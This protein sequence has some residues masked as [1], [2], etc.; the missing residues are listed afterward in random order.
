MEILRLLLEESGASRTKLLFF[1][2]L[3]G[4]SGVLLLAILNSGAAVAARGGVRLPL[5]VYFV[6]TLTL[7][8]LSQKFVWRTTTKTAE[9][10]VHAIRTR[11]MRKIAGCGLE[12]LDSIGRAELYAAINQHAYSISISIPPMIISLQSVVLVAFTVAYL[13]YLSLLAFLL[14][15]IG[16]VAGVAYAISQGQETNRCIDIAIAS[17]QKVYYSLADLLEGFKEVKLN[18][19]RRS[20]LMA[21]AENFSL[22]ARNNRIATGAVVAESFIATQTALYFLL[23]FLVFL[24]PEF[25]PTAYPSTVIKLTTAGLFM[26]GPINSIV[27]IMPTFTYAEAALAAIR[28]T[29]ELLDR[30]QEALH[31][32]ASRVEPFEKL[33]L[34]GI[35]Y[36]YKDPGGRGFTVGPLSFDVTANE[37]VFITGGNGSGKTTMLRVLLG[38][39][40]PKSGR[41]LVNGTAVDAENLAGHRAL[42]STVLSDYHLFARSYGLPRVDPVRAQHLLQR[43]GLAN[44]TSFRGDNFDTLDLSTGQRKRLA[45]VLAILEDRPIMVFDEWAADQDPEFRRIFYHE[46]LPELRQAGKTVIAVT[47]DEKY[48]ACCNRELHMIEGQMASSGASGGSVLAVG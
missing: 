10:I 21:A 6:L 15:A 32:S 40:T 38:L 44:K 5:V 33:E 25:S 47:H 41:I 2:A 13:A 20:E 26:I 36:E 18:D 28:R 17:E 23:A 35:T 8:V 3:G 4:V 29:E 16:I 45:L 46:I 7:S 43:M 14:A 11:L 42:F 27:A 31:P 48:F 37:V 9:D 30:N 22:A 12:N 24:V 1:S 19:R 34:D 39:Y